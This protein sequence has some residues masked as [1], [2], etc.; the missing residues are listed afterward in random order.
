MR[1]QWLPATID[2]FKA[3]SPLL[4]NKLIN[5][6]LKLLNDGESGQIVGPF[7][8]KDHNT[9]WRI[10]PI[11]GYWVTYFI[12]KDI[13]QISA[14]TECKREMVRGSRNATTRIAQIYEETKVEYDRLELLVSR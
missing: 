8:N 4:I 9:V 3:V 12:K 2:D 10:K 14:I 1:I 13:I 11:S 7:A 6:T 5:R